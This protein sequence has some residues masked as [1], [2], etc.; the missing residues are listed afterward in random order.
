MTTCAVCGSEL[1]IPYECN[2]C[3]DTVCKEHMLPENHHCPKPSTQRINP[4][5]VEFPG[6]DSGGRGAGEST[7]L[8]DFI[9]FLIVLIVFGLI[10]YAILLETSVSIGLGI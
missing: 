5:G 10:G 8:G 3:G 1:K 9:T 7:L 2:Y 4:G 6:S